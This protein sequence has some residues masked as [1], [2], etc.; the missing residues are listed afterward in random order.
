MEITNIKIR[1]NTPYP[2]II[3]ANNDART[4]QVLKD[5]LS[6]KEGEITGIMQYF[7]QA[8]IAKQTNQDIA[9]ILEEISIVEM[10]HMELLMDAII[11]FGGNPTYSNS[12]GQPFNA[13]Y[14]NYSTKLKDM[15]DANI[16]GEEQ[17]IKNYYKAQQLV[18]NMSLKELL[19]RIVEDEQLHLQAFKTLRNTVGFLSL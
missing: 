10:E 2:Q 15:L 16:S 6:S 9:D 17:A 1:G 3:N 14:I 7:Y 19:A 5:L 12:Q 11:A 4:V 8:S 18:S 13:N